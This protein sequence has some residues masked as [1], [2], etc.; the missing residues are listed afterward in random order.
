MPLRKLKEI[1]KNYYKAENG[2]EY[3][4]EEVDFL[5]TLKESNLKYNLRHL[6]DRIDF[7][8]DETIK[9]GDFV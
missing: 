1:K 3:C 9:I 5:I 8:N 4:A 2:F 6:S 7:L